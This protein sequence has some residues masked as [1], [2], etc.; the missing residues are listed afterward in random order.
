MHHLYCWCRW[1]ALSLTFRT[2]SVARVMMY[3]G[4]PNV[5]FPSLRSYETFLTFLKKDLSNPRKVK[6]E[7]Q[8]NML[9]GRLQKKCYKCYIVSGFFLKASLIPILKVS[10]KSVN[11]KKRFCHWESLFCSLIIPH[12]S[13]LIPSRGTPKRVFRV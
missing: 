3:R 5:L 9:K 7:K 4:S 6:V 13:L 11:N 10:S 8:I 1:S 12:L 2:S